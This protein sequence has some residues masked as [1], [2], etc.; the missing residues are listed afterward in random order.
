MRPLPRLRGVL[1]GTRSLEARRVGE[2]AN[3][4][5]AR[6]GGQGQEIVVITQERD[7][8]GGDTR[9][10]LVVLPGVIGPGR[11]QPDARARD[12][13]DFLGARIDVGGIQLSSL[14]GRNDLAGTRQ[15]GRGH[16]EAAA[17]ARGLDSA[18]RTAPV[19][20][21]HAVETP[22]CAQ[23]VGQEVLV[24]V[25]VGAVDEVVGTHDRPRPRGSADDLK[26]G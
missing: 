12:V 17:G 26:A 24:F 2:I 14:D 20:D 5:N 22:L 4:G 19:G 6:T 3:E 18:V 7:R 10:Q 15:A 16:F 8:L 11:G 23:D 13:Q 25:R 21:D 9:G 1:G